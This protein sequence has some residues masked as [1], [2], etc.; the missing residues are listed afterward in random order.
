MEYFWDADRN[1][2]VVGICGQTMRCDDYCG[3]TA[4]EPFFAKID[5]Y[6]GRG[7]SSDDGGLGG[8]P[9]AGLPDYGYRAPDYG[10]RAPDYGYRTP[11]HGYRAPDYGYARLDAGARDTGWSYDFG[12]P[13]DRGAYWPDW[14]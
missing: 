1:C 8:R 5:H 9:D 10:C 6:L 7:G 12:W 4:L 11:D 3:S 13:F 14:R 2:N